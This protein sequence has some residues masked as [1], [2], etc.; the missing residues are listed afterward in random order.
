M[1]FQGQRYL[2]YR[3]LK[4]DFVETLE[5][6]GLLYRYALALDTSV[7][8]LFR[9]I[10]DDMTASH[11]RFIFPTARRSSTAA[12]TATITTVQLLGLR[13]RGR[14][15]REL[16]VR[17]RLEP[18]DG[19]TISHLARDRKRFAGRDCFT[20]NSFII[21]IGASPFHISLLVAHILIQLP[22]AP[23]S[24]VYSQ[25]D[26]VTGASAPI[27]IPFSHATAT[28]WASMMKTRRVESRTTRTTRMKTRRSPIF[29]G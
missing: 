27:C 24:P 7:N 18:H 29:F 25:M 12:S 2:A 17:L 5:E 28:R 14:E 16:G 1:I 6:S 15:Y 19:L 10:V 20:Q 21:R 9:R 8:D 13:D 3:I 22:W 23:P 26:A 11:L 4:Q